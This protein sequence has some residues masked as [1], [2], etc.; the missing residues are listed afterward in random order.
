[1]ISRTPAADQ[2]RASRD[3]RRDRARIFRAARIGHDAE[4]A[5]LVA[6][7][8]HGEERAHRTG[9]AARTRRAK[10]RQVVELVLGGE[11]GVERARRARAAAIIRQAVI[12]LRPDDEID[13]GRAA[14]DLGAFGLRDAAGDGDQHAALG[15]ARGPSASRRRPSSE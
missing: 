1:V 10:G 15:C 12:A 9:R 11:L 13:A 14:D 2:A 8:L 5:E 3:D 6:A 4:G 7:F